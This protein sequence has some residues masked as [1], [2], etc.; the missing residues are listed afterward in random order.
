M[1]NVLELIDWA[2]NNDEAAQQIAN[3]GKLFVEQF[4]VRMTFLVPV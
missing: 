2:L 3:N 1:S 4:L